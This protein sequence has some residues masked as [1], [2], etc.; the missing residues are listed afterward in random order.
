MPIKKFLLSED[1]ISRA[2]PTL[3]DRQFVVAKSNLTSAEEKAQ[4]ELFWYRE[5][6]LG[7]M[8]GCWREVRE[9][10]NY[11]SLDLNY[12]SQVSGIRS[13]TLS[14][15]QQRLT[16]PMLENLRTEA[17]RVHMS[18]V[19]YSGDLTD[20]TEHTVLQKG[21][22]YHPPPNEFLYLRTKITNLSRTFG[23]LPVDVYID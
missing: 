12:H 9:S 2:I 16:L 7:S 8:R 23:K 14:L 18:L 10:Q 13:G 1:Q 20:P 3:S 5:E 11:L 21:R 17:T 6:L 15:R 4:R 19:R 22:K